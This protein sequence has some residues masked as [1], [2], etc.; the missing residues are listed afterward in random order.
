MQQ[1][2]EIL[3]RQS[4]LA[5]L[6]NAAT[7]DVVEAR[8]LVHQVMSRA[9]STTRTASADLSESLR[10]DMKALIRGAAGRSPS[11]A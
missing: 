8:F 6:A 1:A 10:R 11:M 4:E 2:L 5:A 9:F 3:S 7:D